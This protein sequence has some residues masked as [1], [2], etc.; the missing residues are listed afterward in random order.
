MRTLHID[1]EMRWGGGQALA[2][3][4]WLHL[5][6]RGDEVIIICRPKSAVERW[7]RSHG[8]ETFPVEMHSTFSPGAVFAIRWI[9]TRKKPDVIH[10]H[11]SRAHVLGAAAARLAK[12]NVVIVTRHMQ[13][14]IHMIWPNT[15]AYG[16]WITMTVAVSDA[17]RNAMAASGVDPAKIRVI[18]GGV[19]VDR[20]ISAVPDPSL[21]GVLGISDRLPLVC[22]AASLT[23]GKGV[24][25]LIEAASILEQDRCSVHLL[26]AG[27]G[28]L[29][30]ELQAKADRLGVRASFIGFRDD[31]PQILASSDIFALPSLAEGFGPCGNRSDGGRKAGCRKPR[32]WTARICDR[33]RNRV[34]GC[35][36]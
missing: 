31:L 25:R 17:V 13:S 28:D 27:K 35:S 7:A 21:R 5:L 12:A 16:G 33:W 23:A 15:S 14:H 8:V 20:I 2:E 29:R 10:L 18:K 24:G 3:A 9:I 1:S 22:C 4:V 19:D 32:G 36:G 11:A 34:F 26:I 30:R 6:E